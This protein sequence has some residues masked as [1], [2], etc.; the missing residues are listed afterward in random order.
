[1]PR[2][3]LISAAVS[4]QKALL[5]DVIRK[6]RSRGYPEPTVHAA[7]DWGTVLT[8]LSGGSLFDDRSVAVVEDADKL[9]EMP[10]RFARMIE[11]EEAASVVILLSCPK[12]ARAKADGGGTEGA[13]TADEPAPKELIS[14]E[15][16]SKCT[17]IKA[18][19]APPPWSKERDAAIRT[20][21]ARYGTAVDP[22]AAGMLKES[23]SD[24]GELT[25]ETDK[26]ARWT[27]ARGARTVT[28]EDV[29]ELCL[30][31]GDRDLLRLLDSICAADAPAVMRALEE[32]ARHFEL[33]P[34]ATA[35][36]NRLR[37]AVYIAEYGQNAGTILRAI[38]SSD[39]ASRMAETAAR[40]YPI[41]ALVD[42]T[43]GLF[44]LSANEKT[45]TGA[46]R[47]D[48]ELLTL[49]LLMSIKKG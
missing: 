17:V 7:S 10:M 40:Y 25:S 11:G 29:S 34:L 39:H 15:L 45:G 12:T 8:E 24:M 46:G 49:D 44:R 43:V 4:A 35:L 14:K 9:G 18:P 6:L 21:A 38:G 3:I 36:N 5:E 26:L 1:M 42:Y 28:A 37:A 20:V 23:F 22:D 13:Q 19:A 2:L 16:I 41:T 27:S 33:I 30:E 31:D 48:L 47:R 32:T